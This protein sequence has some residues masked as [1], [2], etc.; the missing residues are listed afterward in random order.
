MASAFAFGRWNGEAVHELLPVALGWMVARVFG[1]TVWFAPASP[2]ALGR[3]SR[4]TTEELTL[5]EPLD[6]LQIVESTGGSCAQAPF[7][8][9]IDSRERTATVVVRAQAAQFSLCEPADQ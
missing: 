3:G 1:R 8:V 6:G 5:P 4:P 7:A 2:S 9:V